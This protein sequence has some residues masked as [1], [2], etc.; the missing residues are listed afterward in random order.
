M[1]T[2]KLCSCLDSVELNINDFSFSLEIVLWVKYME[3][4]RW[5]YNMLYEA[6]MR[7]FIY[8]RRSSFERFHV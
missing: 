3:T 4:P 1:V 6:A 2:L 5:C 8:A 7:V